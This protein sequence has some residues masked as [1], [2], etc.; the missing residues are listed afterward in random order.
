MHSK[1]GNNNYIILCCVIYVMICYAFLYYIILWYIISYY[2]NFIPFY[3]NY[4]ILYI[5]TH[6]HIGLDFSI[7][8]VHWVTTSD[9]LSIDYGSRGNWISVSVFALDDQPV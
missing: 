3:I 8:L 5:I 9:R 6:E 4:M 2:I 1:L 7:H